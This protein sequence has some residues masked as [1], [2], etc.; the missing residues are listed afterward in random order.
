MT[1]LA[2]LSCNFVAVPRPLSFGGSCSTDA[3][4]QPEKRGRTA[5][6]PSR[7]STTSAWRCSPTSGPSLSPSLSRFLCLSLSLYVS[8][9]VS[10]S[11]SLARASN[12]SL[13][14]SVPLALVDASVSC[15]GWWRPT[16]RAH[17]PHTQHTNTKDGRGIC[18]YHRL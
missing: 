6:A 14:L 1:S 17:S 4:R 15:G 16:F 11:V 7:C 8:V 5:R 13:S 10:L 12:L 2:K 3:R 9:S 18:I